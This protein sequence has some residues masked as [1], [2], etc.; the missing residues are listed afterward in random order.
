MRFCH[1]NDLSARNSLFMQ[2]ALMFS[3][4]CCHEGL[5]DTIDAAPVAC[6]TVRDSCVTTTYFT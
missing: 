3:S 6:V 4:T 1:I 2:L 5:V